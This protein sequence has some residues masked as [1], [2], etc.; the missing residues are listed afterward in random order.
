MRAALLVLALAACN[1]DVTEM[2]VVVGQHGLTIPGDIDKVRVLVFNTQASSPDLPLCSGDATGCITL[3]LVATLVPGPDHPHDVVTVQVTAFSRGQAVIADAASF[4]FQSGRRDR[5]DFTL[6]PD[7]LGQLGCAAQ[8]EACASDGKCSPLSP[9]SLGPHPSFDAGPSDLGAVDLRAVDLQP[10]DL[11][12]SDLLAV[13]DLFAPDLRPA[14]DLASPDLANG[15]FPAHPC[16]SAQSIA[17]SASYPAS[18]CAAYCQSLGLAC[19]DDLCATNRGITTFGVEAWSDA[20]SCASYSTSAGQA[21]CTDNLG[22]FSDPTVAKYRCC[23][24]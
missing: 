20:P 14:P 22:A 12:S 15:G 7:C 11:A 9:T 17:M 23:C 4:V 16:V 24:D 10:V 19:H 8:T 1:A 18:T 21:F 2:V 5:L 3:P 6:Y 13:P